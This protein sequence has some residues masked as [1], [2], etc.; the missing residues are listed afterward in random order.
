MKRIFVSL[1]IALLS[2]L[3]TSGQSAKAIHI[4]DHGSGHPVIF[5]PGF[6]TPGSIWDSTISHLQHPFRILKISYAG[7]NGLKPIEGPWYATIKNQ[8]IAFIEHEELERFSLVGHSMGGNL[9]LDLAIHFPEK[10][11]KLVVVDAIPCMREIMMPGVSEDHIQYESTYNQQMLNMS[12][13]E[14]EVTAQRFTQGM[15]LRPDYADTLLHWSLAADRKTYVYGFTDL[16][17]LDQRPH[18]AKIKAETLI[19]GASFPDA[20]LVKANFQKQYAELQKKELVMA[21]DSRH[22]I[23]IDQPQWFYQQLNGF[24]THE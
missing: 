10:V 18:L 2:N 5:L 19:L 8:L 17:K 13:K 9:A 6:T 4:D 15:T 20:A 7:F 12:E 24:L 1:V 11:T 3:W 21:Q 22:F 16:L 23:M 14:F